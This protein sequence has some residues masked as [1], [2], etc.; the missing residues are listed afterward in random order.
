MLRRQTLKSHLK[1]STW[2][3]TLIWIYVVNVCCDISRMQ[4]ENKFF[5]FRACGRVCCAQFGAVAAHDDK[6]HDLFRPKSNSEKWLYTE[7]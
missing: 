6:L 1:P 3:F 4:T 7:M 2:T 5:S